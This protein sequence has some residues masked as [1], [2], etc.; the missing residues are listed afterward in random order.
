MVNTTDILN[1][2]ALIYLCG[3]A[4]FLISQMPTYA[5]QGSY[6]ATA[7][8]ILD[9]ENTL[10][11]G[12]SIE[13][14]IFKFSI[15]EILNSAG[16][17][18]LNASGDPEI[19]G[20]TD[21]GSEFELAND[22]STSSEIQIPAFV[23]DVLA[24]DKNGEYLPVIV[25]GFSDEDDGNYIRSYA[26][27]EL[28]AYVEETFNSD[29]PNVV[30]YQYDDRTEVQYLP[31]EGVTVTHNL[32]SD[33][34]T[35]K[36]YF[37]ENFSVYTETNSNGYNFTNYYDYSTENPIFAI[38]YNYEDGAKAFEIND[39]NERFF[40]RTNSDGTTEFIYSED[41]LQ[42]GQSTQNNGNYT[43]YVTKTDELG[44]TQ[45]IRQMVIPDGVIT[46]EYEK[47]EAAILVSETYIRD[48]PIINEDG[49]QTISYSGS[50][51]GETHIIKEIVTENGDSSFSVDGVIFIENVGEVVSETDRVESKDSL[52]QQLETLVE[53]GEET[54]SLSENFNNSNSRSID[55]KNVYDEVNGQAITPELGYVRLVEGEENQYINLSTGDVVEFFVRPT[56]PYLENH[57]TSSELFFIDRP[58]AEN[59]VVAEPSTTTENR[60]YVAPGEEAVT[61]PSGE[62]KV[63][64]TRVYV[65]APASKFVPSQVVMP[66][67]ADGD[68]NY[69]IEPAAA[70]TFPDEAVVVA[71]P[72]KEAEAISAKVK[73]IK[74]AKEIPQN[75][76]HDED[77]PPA[78]DPGL[79]AMIKLNVLI[80]NVQKAPEKLLSAT[81]KTIQKEFPNISD[82]LINLIINVANS[83][84]KFD[85][86]RDPKTFLDQEFSKVST[87]QELNS[88]LNADLSQKEL[89]K[90]YNILQ[91]KF[92]SDLAYYG[93]ETLE[94]QK[95][96]FSNN[97]T[98]PDQIME[99][100]QLQNDLLPV[101]SLL[102]AENK[103]Q[104]LASLLRAPLKERLDSSNALFESS[105][106]Q[107]ILGKLKNVSEA[108]NLINSG[109]SVIPIGEDFL[110]NDIPVIEVNVGVGENIAEALEEKLAKDKR[111]NREFQP[112][113]Q[114]SK[115][116]KFSFDIPPQ[117]ESSTPIA[118]P[119]LLEDAPN[120]TDQEIQF[121]SETTEATNNI[122]DETVAKMLK[123]L[124]EEATDENA[125]QM[126]VA[127]NNLS[128]FEQQ[129]PETSETV[130]FSNAL[131][132]V[133]RMQEIEDIRAIFQI[134]GIGS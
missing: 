110:N 19:F 32:Y 89:T 119:A 57:S 81:K 15:N 50:T 43:N 90:I 129:E 30:S 114:S 134:L 33:G 23:I 130:V 109:P 10:N 78:L 25:N 100:L 12:A 14:D 71:I 69:D 2:V 123:E 35:S 13:A 108:I 7:Q 36:Y 59:P 116:E 56:D 93:F 95:V 73:Q 77:T 132:T 34:G 127:R 76:K 51:G 120:M 45:T 106:S 99:Q 64:V 21:Y 97:I 84:E 11:S 31:D 47:N 124:G 44:N 91:Y 4:F 9:R 38:E 86:I 26:N 67:T 96:E 49:T 122:L 133:Q 62:I 79:E 65:Q 5:Q 18:S 22:L 128:P 101:L 117:N 80:N 53:V 3:L 70:E 66:V 85:L 17:P 42:I 28:N 63:Y 37:E 6:S 27:D 111:L 46:L 126:V 121:V 107:K 39:N 20:R 74:E 112:R 68:Y 61:L 83:D 82:E 40:Q 55:F 94:N 88:I 105:Q 72:E 60:I 48:T 102:S 54:I 103:S 118:S 24:E 92:S 104:S 98:S 16:I 29:G 87:A 8:N 75:P 131:S 58:I 115:L 41:Q 125:T 1:R 52:I 113:S